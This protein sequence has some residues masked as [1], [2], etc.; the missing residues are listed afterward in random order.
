VFLDSPGE[1]TYA[2]VEWYFI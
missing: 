1:L 2:F